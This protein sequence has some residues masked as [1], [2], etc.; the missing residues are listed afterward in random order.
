LDKLM[1]GVVLVTDKTWPKEILRV[2]THNDYLSQ[3]Q[4]MGVVKREAY[5]DGRRAVSVSQAT[6]A[7]S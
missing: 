3:L 5:R 1:E 4:N 6:A 7:C 2:P